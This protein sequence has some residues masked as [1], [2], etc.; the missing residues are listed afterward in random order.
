MEKLLQ[1]LNA[2]RGRRGKLANTLGI[3]PSAISMWQQVPA[4]R[5]GDIARATGISPEA[6]RPDIFKAGPK[7]SERAA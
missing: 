3:S 4:E 6:L 7:R 2:E 1:Y 5:L